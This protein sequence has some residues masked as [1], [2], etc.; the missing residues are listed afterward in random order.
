METLETQDYQFISSFGQ[1]IPIPT[2][3]KVFRNVSSFLSTESTL[4]MEIWQWINLFYCNMT[5]WLAESSINTRK[6]KRDRYYSDGLSQLLVKVKVKRLSKIYNKAP[7]L[8]ETYQ[9][10][11][12]L[13]SDW[14]IFTQT[15]YL[16]FFGHLCW[17]TYKTNPQTKLLYFSLNLQLYLMVYLHW[18]QRVTTSAPA[19]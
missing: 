18:K 12:D 6:S 17:F 19:Y 5:C 13:S 4:I 8:V 9:H 1:T 14:T 7:L 10:L 16:F 15:V 2:P 11:K 3:M